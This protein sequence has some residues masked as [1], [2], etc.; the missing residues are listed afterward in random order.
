MIKTVYG[1]PPPDQERIEA[2]DEKLE[3][4][5][6]REAAPASGDETEQCKLFL[7]GLG[8]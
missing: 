8:T 1:S 4:V 2:A 7:S 5:L 3:S 6:V